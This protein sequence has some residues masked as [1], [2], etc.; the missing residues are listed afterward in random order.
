MASLVD[1]LVEHVAEAACYRDLDAGIALLED[2][3]RRLPRRGRPADIE[4]ERAFG[5]GGGVDV[6]GGLRARG[7]GAGEGKN[8]QCSSRDAPA[9]GCGHDRPP[10]MFVERSSARERSK[11]RGPFAFSP[12]P[13]KEPT[14]KLGVFHYLT[15]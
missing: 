13:A 7:E 6:V 9:R 10:Y 2:P 14:A 11:T 5:L 15:R 12:A 3:R 8:D 4:H 1:L